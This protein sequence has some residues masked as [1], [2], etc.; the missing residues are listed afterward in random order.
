MPFL[1]QP[2]GVLF[3]LVLVLAAGAG[4]LMGVEGVAAE[5]GATHWAAVALEGS[6]RRH[7]LPTSVVDFE[8]P[9]W[10]KVG[11]NVACSLTESKRNF[12][13]TAVELLQRFSI[14]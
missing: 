3:A 4:P 9:R 10:E 6:G 7:R 8:V 13:T 1:P 5:G 12:I 14:K 11:E 2:L